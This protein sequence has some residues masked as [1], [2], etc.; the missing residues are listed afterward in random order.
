MN[1]IV[2]VIISLLISIFIIGCGS[3]GGSSS[4][5]NNS[6]SGTNQPDNQGSS[7]NIQTGVFSDAKVYGVKYTQ[8]TRTGTT[9][10]NG[11]FSF[12]KNDATNISFSIGKVNLGNISPSSIENNQTIYP[13]DIIGV[14][15]TETNNTKVVNMLRI[16]QSLDSDGNPF[17]GIEIDSNTTSSLENL[18]QEINIADI[19]DTDTTT[20]NTIVVQE[21]KKTLKERDH[22]IAHFEDTLRR[23]QNLRINTVPPMPPIM[24]NEIYYTNKNYATVSIFGQKDAKVFID[25][26]DINKTISS[27]NY[28]DINISITTA[29]NTYIYTTILQDTNERNS[30]ESNIT[31][32]KDTISPVLNI[33]DT[34]VNENIPSTTVVAT[35]GVTDN[36]P[37][38]FALVGVDA[39]RF[40][41][42][43]KTGEIRFKQ[44]PDYEI[45]RSYNITVIAT[46]AATNVS[47]K[48]I[49]ISI[50]PLNDETPIFTSDVFAV[51]ENNITVG[52]FSITD[53]DIDVAQTFTYSIVGG[54]DKNLF[55]I[56]NN[57]LSFKNAPDFD[58]PIDQN[59]DNK[60]LVDINVSDGI[61]S[62]VKTFTISVTPS[63]D[64]APVIT[65]SSSASF[66]EN[67]NGTV[68]DMSH[69]DADDSKPGM[70]QYFTYS[71]GGTDESYFNI[72]PST[73]VI[74]FKSS[75]DYETKQSYSIT[76][77]VYDGKNY[78]TSQNITISIN[79]LNDEKPLITSTN[80]TSVNENFSGIAHT[81]TKSDADLD[82]SQTFTYSIFGADASYFTLDASS[83][84]IRFISSPDY[85]FKKSYSISA[86]VYDGENYSE[87][88][89]ITISINHLNDEKPSM[90]M[91]Y[92]SIYENKISVS[93][94]MMVI[95]NDEDENQTFTFS[96]SG[97]NDASKFNMTSDGNISFKT[98]PD[99]ENPT[100]SDGDNTYE[101]GITVNDGVNISN[102]QIYSV[103]I[104]P[105]NDNVPIVTS[106][107]INISE[108]NVSVTVVTSIDNDK[109]QNDQVFTYS[110][111]GGVDASKFSIT[112]DGNLSFKVAPDY[113]SP[114]DSDSD[115]IYVVGVKVSDGVHTSSI[116]TL[117]IGVSP[118]NDISPVITS[119]NSTSVN[120]NFL[121]TVLSI[122]SSD[123]DQNQNDQSFTYSIFGT[124]ASLF[125]I[126][127]SS[128]AISFKNAP[129]YELRQNA[130]SFSVKV[131][132]GV[133][134][135]EAQNI[136]VSVNH[137]ND[138]A[139][140]IAAIEAKTIDENTS[141]STVVV[142]VQSSDSDIDEGSATITYSMAGDDSSLFNINS[143]TGDITF[144]SV[145]DY[146]NPQ[147]K[148]KN[149]IFDL[150]LQAS[151]GI[152]TSNTVALQIK[153]NNI[154]DVPDP[155]AY[156]GTIKGSV[157]DGNIIANALIVLQDKNKN[158]YKGFSDSSG[159]Y[160]FSLS[161]NFVGPF[162]LKAYLP[163]GEVLYSYNDGTK[164]VTNITP[165]TTLIVSKFVVNLGIKMDQLFT[166]FSTH[167][168]NSGTNFASYFTN[169]YNSV[170]G[171]F[172]SY[173]F[174]NNL[175]SFNH[176]YNT[177]YPYGFDYDQLLN[178][179]DM[180][181]SGEMITI[182]DGDNVYSSSSS[183]EAAAS[184][185]IPV[186]GTVRDKAGSLVA[187]ASVVATYGGQDYSV[188]T[189]SNGAYTLN[190][191]KYTDFDLN[192]SYSGESISYVNLSTFDT[193]E[194]TISSVTLAEVQFVDTSDTN[195][196]SVSGYLVNTKDNS[197]AISEANVKIRAGYNNQTGTIKTTTKT[198]SDGKYN[199]NLLNG[200]YTFEYSKDK[201]TTK[202][203][204][205]L[206]NS[207]KIVEQQN[208]ALISDVAGISTVSVDL[209]DSSDSGSSNSDNI[210]NDTT[211]TL[212]ADEN[213]TLLVRVS[214]TASTVQEINM[215][216]SNN[217]TVTLNTLSDGE[218]SV[219]GVDSLGNATGFNLLNFTIDSTI[220]K[221]TINLHSNSDSGSSNT[222][223][224]TNDS[225]PYIYTNSEVGSTIVIKDGSTILSLN[226]NSADSSGDVYNTLAKL[227]DGN[228]SLSV[229]ATD[230]AGNSAT[231]DTL[232]IEID[233]VGAPVTVIDMVAGSDSGSSNSDNYTNDTTPTFTADQ[234]VTLKVKP[235]GN[236]EVIQSIYASYLNNYTVTL[237]AISSDGEYVIFSGD[238]D[239]NEDLAG[240]PLNVSYLRFTIDT[241]A[242]TPTLSL[243]NDSGTSISDKITN[244]YRLS[245]SKESESDLYIIEG[246]VSLD[247]NYI[248]SYITLNGELSDGNHTIYA[249]STDKAG[250]TARSSDLNITVDTVGVETATISIEVDS[251][252]G[253]S[254][255]NKI[256]NDTTP[257]VILDKNQTVRVYNG[258]SLVQE[259]N[260]S[261]VSDARYSVTLDTLT[262]GINYKIETG[263]SGTDTAGN[264]LGLSYIYLEIDTSIVVPTLSLYTTDSGESSSDNI[265]NDTTPQLR[266]I[267]ERYNNGYTSYTLYRT[268]NNET[269]TSIASGN[270]NSSGYAYIDIATLADGNYTYFVNTVDSAENNISSSPLILQIDTKGEDKYSIDLNGSKIALIDS[271]DYILAESLELSNR[272][273][274]DYAYLSSSRWTYGD[275]TSTNRLYLSYG[276]YL[277]IDDSLKYIW[278]NTNS[279][280]QEVAQWGKYTVRTNESANILLIED[281]NANKF[282]ISGRTYANDGGYGE[283]NSSISG[284]KIYYHQKYE[285]SQDPS[286]NHIVI[287]NSKNS[288][289]SGYSSYTGTYSLE[290]SNIDEGS[291]VFYILLGGADGTYYSKAQL[292]EFATMLEKSLVYMTADSSPDIFTDRNTTLT[293]KD[294]NNNTLE[295]LVTSLKDGNFTAT[296]STLSNGT[297]FVETGNEGTD[298]AGNILSYSYKNII[299]DT[300][301]S[302][303]TINLSTSSDT[304]SSDSDNITK[305]VN[306]TITGITQLGKKIDIVEANGTILGK[307]LVDSD[308]TYSV[309]LRNLNDGNY[310]LHAISTDSAKNTLSSDTLE[311]QI[312]T[313]GDTTISLSLDSSS[314]SGTS[315]NNITND[316]TPTINTDRYSTIK[317]KDI[318]GTLV[319]ELNTSNNSVTL[320]TL[321]D[322]FY[323]VHG[324]DDAYDIAGNYLSGNKIM[325]QIDTTA[326]SFT[327]PASLENN[328]TVT[329]SS[330]H[331]YNSATNDASS[332]TYTLSGTD[333]SSFSIDETTGII[334]LSDIENSGQTYNLTVTAT[335]AS[336]NSKSQNITVTP[337]KITP[338]NTT[339]F[340]PS[341]ITTYDYFGKSLATSG[342]YFVIGKENKGTYLFKKQSNGSVKEL[343]KLSGIDND[344]VESVAIDGNYIVVG[345]VDNDKAYLFKINSDDNITKLT[346]LSIDN[347]ST[348][349]NSV[350]IDGD[351]IVV[352]DKKKNESGIAY[353]FKINS[354]DNITQ[355]AIISPDDGQYADYFAHSLDIS[356]E[357][358]VV[359]AHG[360]DNIGSGAAYVYKI[361]SDTNL[362]QISKITSSN[363]YIFA[364]DVA[365]DNKTIVV[366]NYGKDEV[367]VYKI[368]SDDT[369]TQVAKLTA[370]D[371]VFDYF[372]GYTVDISGDY[373][374]VGDYRSYDNSYG[375]T[376]NTYNYGAIYLYKIDNEDGITQMKKI[377]AFD[378]ADEDYFGYSFAIDNGNIIVG[379]YEKD[380]LGTNYGAAY[381]ID[382][383]AD[384]PY[385][386]SP[387]NSVEIKESS[388]Q[389]S[390]TIPSVVNIDNSDITYSLSGVDSALFTLNNNLIQSINVLNYE[391]PT[392]N[393]SDNIYEIIINISDTKNRTNSYDLNISIS[394]EKYLKMAK[395]K[396]SDADRDDN[397]GGAIASDGN[398]TIVGA[399]QER[400]NGEYRA[401][402]VY[403]LKKG[404]DG[405][406]K[407][408]DKFTPS[409]VSASDYFGYSVDISGNY[410]VVGAYGD[411][412]NGSNSGAAYLLQIDKSTDTLSQVGDKLLGS[413]NTTYDKSG[414][415]VAID[416]DYIVV[417]AKYD[418]S[419][420]SDGGAAY[421]FKRSGSIV[422]ELAKLTGTNIIP[423][424]YFGGSVDISG[425]YIIIGAESNNVSTSY[426]SA[427]L[428]KRNSDNN[429]SKIK[430]LT[431]TSYYNF[432]HDVAIDGN[433]FV[434][435][436]YKNDRASLFKIV[437]D[438]NISKLTDL[439]D[440]SG[441]FGYS[442]DIDNSKII[443][444]D[445]TKYSATIF[446]INSDTNITKTTSFSSSGDRFGFTVATSG[447]E[448]VIGAMYD[449]ETQSSSGAIYQ[450]KLDSN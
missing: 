350:A 363:G 167:Y 18:S 295:T 315:G 42:N 157:N 156:T 65:S 106:S 265:T 149:N 402:S 325:I 143:S 33:N 276:N 249:S 70:V 394:D 324:G 77:M 148:N 356:G 430:K 29:D 229:T 123:A 76:A 174:Q 278:N 449:S 147:D 2:G 448:I 266:I 150:T 371:P 241:V 96:I 46:D 161:S 320:S 258:S 24:D 207:T 88:Q 85:E 201:Y 30:S 323:F 118:L 348:F 160:S 110:I 78:S 321:S 404:T 359:G 312:D 437:G 260:V 253:Y 169:S 15:K 361:N 93:N 286:A 331:V 279:S 357:Y 327:S 442:V 79:H 337:Q 303:P 322:G 300:N 87:I 389:I 8:G 73:G 166:D 154:W 129:D 45:K 433:Y 291:F 441:T 5:N 168:T 190:I 369:I 72:N 191:P 226:D 246:I 317:I 101:M 436:N 243:Y 48:T 382:I 344:Y 111:D 16:L 445:G 66:D 6:D 413:S 255:S 204:S 421:L 135:S 208:I 124:D 227:G 345:A 386:L 51:E 215:T 365:I 343:A 313:Y 328:S 390:Y 297:Y 198:G 159:N 54:V 274:F 432:G 233:T 269:N 176:V 310:T 425:D 391:S 216:A 10:V 438:N 212:S 100:D 26:V 92:P 189:D 7:E 32:I 368:A 231:S 351:Y 415:D 353:L 329:S 275:P 34:A 152:N 205:V 385:I 362:T 379:A 180:S 257:T 340:L 56:S 63:N 31:V 74:T 57:I 378:P 447:D 91:V 103:T 86:R 80:T 330:L 75:P 450:Y 395:V 121:G 202:Y 122:T 183:V 90:H 412:T 314:D 239:K 283:L 165:I 263:Q 407:Q 381:L 173:L 211:P 94:G 19:D 271:L 410:V 133:N 375:Y 68:L 443:I 39:N 354:D 41:I 71:L 120:E 4:S 429:I 316:T 131:N 284:F 305:D 114:T 89:T 53:A 37:V 228:H 222:D 172:S 380:G 139:P 210:T 304:G 126:N 146:E 261:K 307:G 112:S 206:V 444:G 182:R 69:S 339:K 221:P 434:V 61:N 186:S 175:T 197:L 82:E 292:Q 400:A 223:N 97:G 235:I 342:D 399:Y 411:D 21:A 423:N 127:S 177:F 245:Y 102:V 248:Y 141:T 293:L 188:N 158:L 446:T 334:T 224:I 280:T 234:N 406:L 383:F 20:L 401:G 142:T 104:M 259:H 311:L 220:A 388:S 163:T 195:E 252:K 171:Y 427:Y 384:K 203:L 49:T 409:N 347:P 105:V 113:E 107:D 117:N 318:N 83:G 268:E 50:N 264:S 417:G 408:V 153:L 418:D 230:I 119:S 199:L 364:L 38:F 145:P 416:G 109:D 377:H 67:A 294:D 43:A 306:I 405:I 115:N 213:A 170:A 358:I 360:E 424:N 59:L 81:L 13:T 237:N 435:T 98:A 236:E 192:I 214:S 298:L 336:G 372:F 373:I 22:V 219:V 288:T 440:T 47:R 251:D 338:T 116:K 44:S 225:T 128:G 308:G 366:G 218:Y 273:I 137:L 396:A 95:D 14:E 370:G 209:M 36:S 398:Y 52:T 301:S 319:Q 281:I 335:D 60:Y 256:T 270:L 414:I 179:V 289:F 282:K 244:D 162:I 296:T 151:D 134:D 9:N 267:G 217:Y 55:S 23:E 287:T 420:S 290:L 136:T 250:N 99:Y 352:G 374:V 422:S 431:D 272:Y 355:N 428:F 240:N 200:N 3:G 40:N 27:D 426:D 35:V 254:S 277:Y 64:N 28:V 332:V 309:I 349:G 130:Y 387:Q 108:N 125:N 196:K 140:I 185:T 392:D 367:Y 144:K 164:E 326:P 302:K 333:A 262:N 184:T 84:E 232:M 419:S 439:T 403:L 187:N 25:S 346:D 1:K 17:N 178:K 181:I 242:M 12:D 397:F 299:I 193:N 138:E 11:E 194:T 62:S 247:Y 132:D 376:K 58:N 155:S 238:F 393:N 341:D 285:A